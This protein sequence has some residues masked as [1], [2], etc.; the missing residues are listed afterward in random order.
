MAI[1]LGEPK[2]RGKSDVVL[3]K[4]RYDGADIASGQFAYIHTDGTLRASEGNTPAPL[5]VTGKS[6]GATTEA[7]F[8]GMEVGVRVDDGLT[9]AIGQQVYV[10]NA[11][12]AITNASADA[13]AVNATF[14]SAKDSVAV[15]PNTGAVDATTAAAYIT[16]VG[17]L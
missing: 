7:V 16:F 1:V 9:I 10:V 11:T 6:T 5:C 15:N 2:Q 4:A 8:S 12:G 3:S 17:G 13:T 14:S